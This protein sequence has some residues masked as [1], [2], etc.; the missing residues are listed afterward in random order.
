MPGLH[1]VR[2]V[3]GRG[4]HDEVA[5]ERPGRCSRPRRRSAARPRPGGR[6]RSTSSPVFLTWNVSVPDGRRAPPTACT[7]SRTTRRRSS[8]RRR[9]AGAFE[10][11]PASAGSDDER[12]DER[13]RARRARRDAGHRDSW[14]LAG[15]GRA[16]TRPGQAIRRTW[17][18]PGVGRRV[19]GGD[20]RRAAARSPTPGARTGSWS[21][22]RR[23]PRRSTS[24]QVVA[25]EKLNTPL[26]SVPMMLDGGIVAETSKARLLRPGRM[27][28]SWRSWIA[29]GEDAAG[30]DDQEQRRSRRRT[31]RRLTFSAP[32]KSAQPIDE[33]GG[34]AE[35]RADERRRAVA[36]GLLRV[37]PT[38][39]ARSRGPR[40]RRRA[41]R[42]RTRAAGAGGDRRRRASP[43]ARARM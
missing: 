18:P 7:R 4:L 25:G 31:R 9:C 42:R 32:R 35:Q 33:R 14:R 36:C 26:R 24:S 10:T 40:G 27:P 11:Q 22:R 38:G 28:A 39:T 37:R 13:R 8:R 12:E 29:V 19:V 41:S 15:L 43:G 6:T 23:R 1:A 20:A 17:V 5:G 2:Y 34:E 30:D 3:P 21:A 16:V